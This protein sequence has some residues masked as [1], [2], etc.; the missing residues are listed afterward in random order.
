M[1]NRSTRTSGRA[2]FGTPAYDQDLNLNG[3]ADG[4]EYDRLADL[5]LH[6]LPPDGVVSSRDAQAAFAQ[7]RANYNCSP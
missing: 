3:I 1:R 2:K 4:I 7:F 5:A 6:L